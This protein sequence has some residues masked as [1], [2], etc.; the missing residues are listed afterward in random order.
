MTYST[1]AQRAERASQWQEFKTLSQYPRV[2]EYT[3]LSAENSPDPNQLFIGALR[4]WLAKR[5]AAR[6]TVSYAGEIEL[7]VVSQA[8]HEGEFHNR[9]A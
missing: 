2:G 4:M 1:Q 8:L 7:G 5:A 6:R 9:P 3:A